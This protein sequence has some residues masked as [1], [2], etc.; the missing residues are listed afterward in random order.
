MYTRTIAFCAALALAP[1]ALAQE[2]QTA[3][4]RCGDKITVNAQFEPKQVKL[5]MGKRVITLP[6]RMSD[7]RFQY[8]DRTYE[9]SG[10]HDAPQWRVAYRDAVSCVKTG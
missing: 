5:T 4:Y 8:L 9:F 3:S 7:K 10:P 1:A 2:V 6:G